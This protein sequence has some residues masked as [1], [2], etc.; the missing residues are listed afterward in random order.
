M[1]HQVTLTPDYESQLLRYLRCPLCSGNL[2]LP[3]PDT[4][5]DIEAH[6]AGCGAAYPRIDGIWQMLTPA[7]QELYR[8]F[9][10][11]YPRLRR[12]EG[13]ERDEAYFLSLPNVPRDD[14]AA[15][16]WGIRKRSLAVLDR[17]LAQEART[18][19]TGAETWALDLGAGNGW[20]S[21]HL[22]HRG[23]RTV[24]L[25][26][27]VAGLDSLAGAQLYIEHEHIWLGRVQASMSRPPFADNTFTLCAISAALHYAN[28][29]E[30]LRSAYRVLKPGGLLVITDSP[31]Y[32]N[33]EAGRAMAAER[34]AQIETL[35]GTP[36]PDLPGGTNF[37]V[38][39]E[40]LARMADTG[41]AIQVIP[42]ERIVGR[43]KRSLTRAAGPRSR[44][45]ARFPAHSRA[46]K[47][48]RSPI[49]KGGRSVQNAPSAFSD[50]LRFSPGGI[51]HDSRCP[52]RPCLN[53]HDRGRRLLRFEPACL[54]L[55]S[56]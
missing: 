25:D 1:E 54:S 17:L 55:D 36:P 37:L 38:E 33:V 49:R 30:T 46:K 24:A 9:L 26:L 45:H 14:P 7:E 2:V 56:P 23:Y 8:S 48:K 28:E 5:G 15:F 44:E 51:A 10:E 20:L 47:V 31:V 43:L 29:E 22:T 27:T 19:G 16:V 52:A 53:G 35:L 34:E 13:W 42:V 32:T 50:R 21:R 4:G 40:L 3:G 11:G 39:P 18:K 12:R 41:F 6:C